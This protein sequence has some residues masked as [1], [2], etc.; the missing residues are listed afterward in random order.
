MTRSFYPL[1]IA[2]DYLT[3]RGGAERVV[4]ALARTFPGAPV[5][6]SLYEPEATYPEFRHLD[7]RPTVLS[8]LPAARRNHR[9]ALPLLAPAMQSVRI[10][11]AVTVCSSSGWA[12]GVRTTGRKVVY[13]HAPA[14]WLYQS[15]RYLEGTPLL[16]RPAL[17]VL[18]PA[19][20]R[21]DRRA[22]ASADRYLAGSTAVAT[23]VASLYGVDVEVLPPPLAVDP[24]GEGRPVLGID[25][26]YVLCVSR[27]MAYKNV[28][29][30]IEAFARLPRERL[31]V[32]GDGPLRQDLLARAPDNVTILGTVDD[33]EL[34]W[35][36]RSSSALVS[37]SF[38]D[39]GLSPIE[40]AAF[41]KPSA[42][43][44]WGGFLDTLV[45]GQT[46]VY[47]ERPEPG[48]V[49]DAVYRLRR[50]RF[51]SARLEAHAAG[52][53]PEHFA[54]RMREVVR[55]VTGTP[56][57]RSLQRTDPAAHLWAVPAGVT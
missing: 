29:A 33:A 45:E 23:L 15:D 41:G 32:V 19:L 28:G 56:A 40:A 48:A 6:T 12:H 47:I 4:I 57:E 9:S 17:A 36:Y 37:A 35:L 50:E 38:E 16:A 24:R 26:G 11:A 39:F 14:R 21:W 13:C 52:Y 7:V 42:V 43:L 1:A 55:E 51:D 20:R 54:R 34:R 2:H 10:D 49:A 3:Q 53:A 22:A 27:L 8:R 31:V 46:G 25:P 18:A 44:R 5:Y 30:V